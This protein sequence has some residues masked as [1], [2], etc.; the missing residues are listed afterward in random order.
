MKVESTLQSVHTRK[1]KRNLRYKSDNI[2]I[3]DVDVIIIYTGCLAYKKQAA[4]LL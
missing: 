3:I 2:H 1:F 4:H